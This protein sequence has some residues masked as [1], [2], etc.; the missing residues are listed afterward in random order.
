M[1][2]CAHSLLHAMLLCHYI[3]SSQSQNVC[4]CSTC[5]TSKNGELCV[6]VHKPIAKSRHKR[7]LIH[8]AIEIQSFI[9]LPICFTLIAILS[10]LNYA[11]LEFDKFHMMNEI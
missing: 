4:M 9:Y 1:I 5:K 8:V 3:L 7:I 10:S 6:G 11:L 2:G